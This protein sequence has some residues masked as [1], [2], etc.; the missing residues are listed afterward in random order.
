MTGTGSSETARQGRGAPPGE[1][2][3]RSCPGQAR[4]FPAVLYAAFALDPAYSEPQPDDVRVTRQAKP[5][6]AQAAQLLVPAEAHGCMPREF[7][8]A[9][10]RL[11]C[12]NPER[13]THA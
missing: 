9:D 7:P 6:G 1:R 5:E 12:A 2:A 8:T 3:Q 13:G 4:L 10:Q 11:H